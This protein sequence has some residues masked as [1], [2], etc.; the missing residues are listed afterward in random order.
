MKSRG[1]RAQRG[2]ALLEFTL[3]AIPMVFFLISTVELTR[4]MW[5]Y[6]TLVNAVKEGTRFTVVHGQA[7]AQAS[8]SCPV[9]L[10]AVATVVQQAATGI[11]PSQFNVTMRAGSATQTC[12]P[13]ASC[14]SSSAAWPPTSNNSVGLP[15]K[16]SGTYA[17]RSALSM[18]WPGSTP[19]Q[20]IPVTLGAQSQEEILF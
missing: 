8:N 16:I 14:L 20:I 11:D 2:N 1:S 3:V 10:G 9:T 12:A 19:A 7:C 6:G 4:G 17:F 18:F 5:I 13:L 15:V